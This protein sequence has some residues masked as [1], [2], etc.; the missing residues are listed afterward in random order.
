MYIGRIFSVIASEVSPPELPLNLPR[1][2]IGY[3]A[4]GIRAQT[5]PFFAIA[6]F[7]FRQISPAL[8]D[9]SIGLSSAFI[10]TDTLMFS[11][12]SMHSEISSGHS[13]LLTLGVGRGGL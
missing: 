10:G 9:T 4:V 12:L 1:R 2:F 11:V 13:P 3:F 5:S 6:H 8:A 7:R